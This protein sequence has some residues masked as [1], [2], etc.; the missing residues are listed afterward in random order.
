[1]SEGPGNDVLATRRPYLAAAF[2]VIMGARILGTAL[3]PVLFA[4]APLALLALSPVPA[5]LV[6]VAGVSSP[7]AYWAVAWPICVGQCLLAYLF[8]RSEGTHALRWLVARGVASEGRVERLMKPMRM[9]APLLVMAVPGPIASTLAG[10]FAAPARLLVPAIVVAQTL[11]IGLCRFFGEALL[12]WI[13]VLRAEV[14]KHA[15]PLTLVTVVI[16]AFVHFRKK[17]A[18]SAERP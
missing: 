6:L 5:N 2:V 4:H 13:A 3:S 12:G 17:W 9:S 15:L 10:A 18:K 7:V 16:V 8:G 14:V 11:W 1:M